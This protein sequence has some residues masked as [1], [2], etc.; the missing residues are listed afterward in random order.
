MKLSTP[1]VLLLFALGSRCLAQPVVDTHPNSTVYAIDYSTG[2][3]ALATSDAAILFKDAYIELV[4]NTTMAKLARVAPGKKNFVITQMDPQTNGNAYQCIL[5][6]KL[7]GQTTTLLT[8]IYSVDKNALSFYYAES[9]S[10]LNVQIQGPNLN[11]LTNCAAYGKFNIPAPPPV[12]EVAAAPPQANVPD[13]TPADA[14]DA[15]VSTATVP[16]ALPDYEQPPCPTDGY[17]WQPG[18]WAFNAGGGY[19]WVPGV[20]VAAPTVGLLWTPPYWGFEGGLY[21]FHAGYWGNTIGFYGGVNYGYGYGGRGYGGGEWHEGHFRYNTAVVRVN[22]VVIHNTY[23]D[24]T[25]IVVGE[26][27]HTGFNGGPGGI[28]RRADEHEMAAMH[29]HHIMATNEQIRNQRAAR[30]DRSQFASSNGG[31]PGNVAASRPPERTAENVRANE[32]ARPGGMN[33]GEAARSGGASAT[34]GAGGA[35]RPGGAPATPGTAGAVKPAG[36]AGPA[37]PGAAKPGV[38]G[39]PGGPGVNK[40]GAAP[41]TGKGLPKSVS[42]PKKKK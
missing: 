40:P 29:E 15:D 19:Y 32:G 25:V 9:Q 5:Q 23:E 39:V 14:I 21:L 12:Q 22:T 11:N 31:R 24:R 7:F 13:N 4:S 36:A 27:N 30:E 42:P 37:V 38:P 1:I 41:G 2:Q 16:P 20:W 35:T 3:E 33:N 17:M 26:R 10:Y 8:F 28:E 6:N 34:P 18:Y